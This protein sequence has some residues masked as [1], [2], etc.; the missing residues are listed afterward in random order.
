MS[1]LSP[2]ETYDHALVKITKLAEDFHLLIRRANDNLPGPGAANAGAGD[3]GFDID[4]MPEPRSDQDGSVGENGP[5]SRDERRAIQGADAAERDV[6][7]TIVDLLE[8]QRRAE[9]IEKRMACYRPQHRLHD[10]DDVPY[11]WCPN[12]YRLCQHH[13]PTERR[14]KPGDAPGQQSGDKIYAQGWCG[15]CGRWHKDRGWLP[16]RKILMLHYARQTITI[17]VEDAEERKLPRALKPKGSG[18]RGRSPLFAKDMT[19]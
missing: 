12:C 11:D 17:T 10:P 18:R 3:G 6:E 9:N 15:F 2:E 1:K 4:S 16:T 8:M 7:L 19:S 13:S 14:K 5:M